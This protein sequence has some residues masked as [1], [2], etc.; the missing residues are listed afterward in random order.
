MRVEAEVVL[1]GIPEEAIVRRLD[2]Y[3]SAVGRSLRRRLDILA[4]LRSLSPTPV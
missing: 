1:A 3:R 2:R 4:S